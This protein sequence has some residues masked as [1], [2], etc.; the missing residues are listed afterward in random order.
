M[1][2][3]TVGPTDLKLGMHM[4]LDPGSNLVNVRKGGGT[5]PRP[6]GSEKL[7]FY[8]LIALPSCTS[9]YKVVLQTIH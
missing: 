4:Q 8:I 6:A 3:Q 5:A 7:D 2:C 1:A 9:N